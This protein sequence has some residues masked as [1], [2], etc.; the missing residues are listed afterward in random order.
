M[1]KAERLIEMMITI[2]AKRDFTVGELAKEF[3]VSKRT[4]LR[5]PMAGSSGT[6]SARIWFPVQ[7]AGRGNT[8]GPGRQRIWLSPRSRR[9]RWAAGCVLSG[10]DTRIGLALLDQHQVHHFFHK[11]CSFH[12]ALRVPAQLFSNAYCIWDTDSLS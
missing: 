10:Y 2:N 1:S 5:D 4:I 12:F 3:S 7:K 11:I 6:S 9:K 8:A